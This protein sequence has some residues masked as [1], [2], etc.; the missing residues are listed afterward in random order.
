M[1]LMTFTKVGSG[2][3][4][5]SGDNATASYTGR[6]IIDAGTISQL[7]QIVTLEILIL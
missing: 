1:V 4:T 3:L 7:Q 5:L 2:T 6:V